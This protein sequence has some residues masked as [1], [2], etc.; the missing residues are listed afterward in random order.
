MTNNLSYLPNEP[1]PAHWETPESLPTRLP[2]F[3]GQDVTFAKARLTS[4]SGME[5][6]DEVLHLDQIVSMNVEGRVIRIDHVVNERTGILERVQTIKV[7]EGQI[8]ERGE[9]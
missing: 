9:R 2:Q 6:D 5:I 4:V 8:T 3:E 1:A 7:I